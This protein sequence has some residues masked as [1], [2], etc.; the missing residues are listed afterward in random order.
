MEQE[1]EDDE[2]VLL[3]RNTDARESKHA[4]YKARTRI[5]RSLIE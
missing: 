1:E 5:P 2:D 3:S 4:F